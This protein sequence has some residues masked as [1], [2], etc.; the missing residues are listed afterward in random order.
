MKLGGVEH[1]GFDFRRG[2]D[3]ED[4]AGDNAEKQVVACPVMPVPIGVLAGDNREAV[5]IGDDGGDHREQ[6]LAFAEIGQK[7]GGAPAG[8]DVGLDVH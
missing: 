4:E 2:E 1:E 8:H 5:Q 7:V 6:T 3:R